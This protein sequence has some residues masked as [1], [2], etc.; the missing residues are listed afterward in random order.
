MKNARDRIEEERVT[1]RG[2]KDTNS[3]ATGCPRSG[4]TNTNCG[5]SSGATSVAQF[6]QSYSEPAAP[7][8]LRVDLEAGRFIS[9]QEL[10][11]FVKELDQ[12]MRDA[13]DI[14]LL[15]EASPLQ[16][17]ALSDLQLTNT[18]LQQVLRE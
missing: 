10:I 13:D 16:R 11:E 7:I 3:T 2:L 15:E 12:R 14:A 6:G 5:C 18:L 4:E 1:M 17:S 9:T 8:D